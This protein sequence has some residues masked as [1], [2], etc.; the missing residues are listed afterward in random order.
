MNYDCYHSYIYTYI[1]PHTHPRKHVQ[2]MTNGDE[3]YPDEHA[4]DDNANY[5]DVFDTKHVVQ[6]IE[7]IRNNINH[8][9]YNNSYKLYFDDEYHEFNHV[10]QKCADNERVSTA[11]TH[12]HIKKHTHTHTHVKTEIQTKQLCCNNKTAYIFNRF[13]LNFNTLTMLKSKVL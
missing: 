9:T 4:Y 8:S 5:D 1:H 11:S 13:T 12:I 7:D 10:S 2:Y 6:A 3:Q